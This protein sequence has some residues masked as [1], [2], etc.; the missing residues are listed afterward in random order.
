MIAVLVALVFIGIVVA[1]M[2]R[3]TGSQSGASIGYGTMQT[4]A[5]TTSS[6]IIAT[7][8]YVEKNATPTVKVFF[9]QIAALL[10]SPQDTQYIYGRVN[11]KQ[12]LA[13]GQFFRSRLINV[14]DVNPEKP[15]AT[16]EITSGRDAGRKNLKRAY[17]FYTM[18]DVEIK[19]DG[20]FPGMNTFE[21]GGSLTGGNGGAEIEGYATFASKFNV[22]QTGKPITFKKDAKGQGDV[23]FNDAAFFKNNIVKFEVNAYFNSDVVFQNYQTLKFDQSVGFNK[24]VSGSNTT[25]IGVDGNVWLKEEFKQRTND[26]D[27]PSSNGSS[28]YSG[29]EEVYFNGAANSKLY[30]TD[31]LPIAVEGS[32]CKLQ[33]G[34]TCTIHGK[35]PDQHYGY[36]KTL[37]INPVNTP[38]LSTTSILNS[39]NMTKEANSMNAGQSALEARKDPNLDLSIITDV[40]QE[41]KTFLKLSDLLGNTN[42]VNLSKIN[43]WY[44]DNKKPENYYNGHLL[45]EVDKNLNFSTNNTDEV[46]NKQ[47]I[48][49]VKDG[50]EINANNNFY[51]SGSIASTMVYVENGPNG[52]GLL[53]NFGCT[54][55]FRG[56]LYIEEGNTQNHKFQWGANSSIDGAVLLKGGDLTWNTGTGGSSSGTTTITRNEDILRTFAGLAGGSSGKTAGLKTGKTRVDLKAAGYYFY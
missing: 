13:P 9:E 49:V 19:N 5:V 56:L 8:S 29:G 12:E 33:T 47:I 45:V 31:E 55:A 28:N 34:T 20:E 54:D 51:N 10:K 43:S 21:M 15:N 26:I 6:G 24:N 44:E 41:G 14:S 42:E 40:D 35:W 37:D 2:L 50:K 27:N 30:Y 23:F 36:T 25:P 4:M 17:A 48:F 11:A 32:N 22:N 18:G 16:F 52:G 39:L 46:F 3:N 1:A 38:T 7:E 53:N